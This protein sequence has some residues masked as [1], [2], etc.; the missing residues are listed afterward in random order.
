MQV[1]STLRMRAIST[2]LASTWFPARGRVTCLSSISYHRDATPV[3][4][5]RPSFA[6]QSNQED[7]GGNTDAFFAVQSLRLACSGVTAFHLYHTTAPRRQL[8]RRAL[9]LLTKAIKRMQAEI[10][11]RLSPFKARD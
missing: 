5:P 7:A 8:G 9:P 1:L 11:M 3:R 4:A 6:Y 2:P 10:R